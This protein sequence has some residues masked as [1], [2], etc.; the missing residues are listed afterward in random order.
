M[1]DFKLDLRDTAISWLRKYGVKY[2]E[3][4]DTMAMLVKYYTFRNKYVDPK[5]RKVFPSIELYQKVWTLP[6][7]VQEAF[8]KLVEWLYAGEDINCFQGRGL[9]GSGSRDY[10][11]TLYGIIHLHLS[12][13]KEDSCPVVK[14]DGFAARG[15]YLLFAIFGD[16]YALLLDIISHPDSLIAGKSGGTEWTSAN[17]IKTIENNWPNILEK[18]KLPIDLQLNGSGNTMHLSDEEIAQLT[19]NH[20]S[21]IVEGEK[22]FYIPQLGITSSGDSVLAVRAAQYDCN[23]AKRCQIYYDAHKEEIHH[24][25]CE[26][27]LHRN[28]PVPTNWDIHFDYIDDLNRSVIHDRHTGAGFDLSTGTS[29]IYR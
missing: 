29:K 8:F 23:Y 9:Y 13:H 28:K 2:K 16:E 11:N 4:D 15:E 1:P 3:K 17:L 27:L 25:F 20:I 10:Q 21:F 6:P 22:G 7:R 14:K 19:A 24:M 26:L 18:T 12:A 5:R